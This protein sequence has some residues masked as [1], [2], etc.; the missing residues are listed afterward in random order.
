MNGS[1][2][3]LPIIDL[4]TAKDGPEACQVIAERLRTAASEVGFFYLVNHS[5]PSDLT[6]RA[7]DHL[8]RFFDLHMDEKM[9]VHTSKSEGVRG[10]VGFYEQGN[11]GLDLTDKRESAPATQK[12]DAKELFCLGHAL[13]RDHPNYHGILF[14]ENFW[15]EHDPD[16]KSTLDAYYKETEILAKQLYSLFALGLGLPADYFD[17]HIQESPMNSTNCLH[18]PPLPPDAPPDQMGIGEHTD[19]ECFTLLSTDSTPGLQIMAS[20]GSWFDVPPMP[21][22][23]VVNIGDMMARWSNDL[24]RSTV[25]RAQNR[26]NQHRYAIA[27]FKACNFTTI[28]RSLVPGT[29]KYAPICAGEHMLARVAGANAPTVKDKVVP[30]K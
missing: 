22:G 4:S 21:E 7:Y 16:F 23:F 3:S 28:L 1:F 5:V 12:M 10:Y 15:P 17:S 18:Y 6:A 8:R 19:Y 30:P 2:A 9:R 14:A 25:H 24:F 13:P 26:T 29:E 27:S 11:Y 20:D